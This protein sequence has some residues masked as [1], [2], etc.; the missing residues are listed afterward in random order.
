M[1]SSHLG[2]TDDYLLELVV[3]DED[4]PGEGDPHHERQQ[5]AGVGHGQVGAP[6][7]TF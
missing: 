1:N 3:G 6:G 4:C 5:Q 2:L 7:Q